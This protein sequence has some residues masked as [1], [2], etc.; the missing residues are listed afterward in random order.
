MS[1]QH[2]STRIAIYGLGSFVVIVILVALLYLRYADVD[3]WKSLQASRELGAIHYSETVHVESIFRTRANT[4][5]NLAFV[6]VGCFAIVAAWLDRRTAP[7]WLSSLTVTSP[8]ALTLLFGIAC[9]YLGVGSGIFHASLTRWGQQLDVASMYPPM[10]ALLAMVLHRNLAGPLT[11]GGPG[12][13]V[14]VSMVLIFLVLL[15]AVLLYRYKWSMSSGT[16]LPLHVLALAT[17]YT[18]DALR[19]RRLGRLRWL[20]LS[21]LALFLG[22][23]CRQLDVAGRFS[24]PDAWYQG[25]ALWHV[26][27]ALSLGLGWVYLRLYTRETV[28]SIDKSHAA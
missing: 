9:C 27:C 16:V 1:N 4:W 20:A 19:F 24:G 15:A 26:W 18:L 3:V 21:F 10:L 8:P 13:S 22:V 14:L 12:R 5:S 28:E 6:L 23:V 17:G 11:K 7:G 25:H 2:V